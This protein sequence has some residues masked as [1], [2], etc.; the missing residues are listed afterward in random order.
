MREK[1]LSIQ[2]GKIV[3]WYQGS[4]WVA[5]TQKV[6]ACFFL[7]L[8]GAA[9]LRSAWPLN[10]DFNFFTEMRTSGWIVGESEYFQIFHKQCSVNR[11]YCQKRLHL[12]RFQLHKH[13]ICG[14]RQQNFWLSSKSWGHAISA[15]LAHGK[16][17]FSQNVKFIW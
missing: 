8:E 10:R 5:I 13:I 14:H 4:G 1:L 15:I 17:W 12:L 16:S 11:I 9:F 2:Q 7:F 3:S 6:C